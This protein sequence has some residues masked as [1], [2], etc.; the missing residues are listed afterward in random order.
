MLLIT[1][2]YIYL[3]RILAKLK[4][5]ETNTAIGLRYVAQPVDSCFGEQTS[6]AKNM[7]GESQSGSGSGFVDSGYASLHDQ[8][9]VP[10]SRTFRSEWIA[11]RKSPLGGFGIFA[12]RDIPADTH[13]LL[14]QPFISVSR[15][16]QLADKYDRLGEEEKLVFDGLYGFDRTSDDP[17]KKR[18]NANR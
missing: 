2:V 7:D 15:A 8:L 16:S 3:P 6:N 5:I 14:E 18:W 4:A 9:L 17:V 10:P 13:F 11:V 1:R 12:A